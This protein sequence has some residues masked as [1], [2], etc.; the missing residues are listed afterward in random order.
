[1]NTSAVMDKLHALLVFVIQ[2]IQALEI[3]FYF[4]N[5]NKPVAL[6]CLRVLFH[7]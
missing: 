4:W 3:Y 6:G 1:M 7:F 2:F 5:T